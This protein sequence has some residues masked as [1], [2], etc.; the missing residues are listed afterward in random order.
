MIM[1]G[2]GLALSLASSIIPSIAQGITGGKQ[3]REAERLR[4]GT[5]RPTYETPLSAKKALGISEQQAT[6]GLI[7]RSILEDRLRGSTASAVR[8]TEE[9][10]TSPAS[11]LAAIT[12]TYGKEMEG[13]EDIA[14]ADTQARLEAANRLSRAYGTMAD[15][16]DREFDINEQRP[17]EDTMAAASAL[18]GAGMQNVQGS[19]EGLSRAGAAALSGL[20]DV[21]DVDDFDATKPKKKKKSTS[22][23]GS[24]AV[25]NSI[26]LP[27]TLRR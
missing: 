15:Y 12:A 8:A 14:I 26:Y 7:G 20:G 4:K 13:M 10:A 25:S 23:I 17:F 9:V 3:K 18:T 22:N 24:G 6:Q 27:T 21:E 11:R 1:A 5:T 19:L 2:I 16:E